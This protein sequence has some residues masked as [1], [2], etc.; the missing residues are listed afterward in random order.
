MLARIAAIAFLTA[1]FVWLGPL[2]SF[3]DEGGGHGDGG[4]G[5]GVGSTPPG[6]V[7]SLQPAPGVADGC[8]MGRT[9]DPPEAACSTAETWRML[10][11]SDLNGGRTAP[12]K[13][14]PRLNPRGLFD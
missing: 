5:D 11:L 10:S 1:L 3:A 14:D 8:H 13:N 7:A 9:T 6:P 12:W 2:F 4:E